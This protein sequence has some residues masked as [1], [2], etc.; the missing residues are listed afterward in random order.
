MAERAIQKNLLIISGSG[1]RSGKTTLAC[2]L[3][4]YFSKQFPVTAVKISPHPNHSAGLAELLEERSGYRV[5]RENIPNEKDSGLFLEAGADPSYFLE[6][7]DH[8]IDLAWEFMKSA[9]LEDDF[10]IICES[11]YL[12]HLVKPGLM[13][14]SGPDSPN[15]TPSKLRN[16][17][18]SDIV[19]VP[20]TYDVQTLCASIRFTDGEWKWIRS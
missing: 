13:F 15:M 6:V 7:T 20:G 1:R 8:N 12:G 18:L 11:G 16:K 10:P 17:A 2:N 4:R 14:F 5:Y 19:V 3:I 9:F